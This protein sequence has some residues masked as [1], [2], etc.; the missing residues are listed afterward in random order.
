MNDCRP[1]CATLYVGLP[2]VGCSALTMCLVNKPPLG[3]KVYLT[4]ILSLFINILR[5]TSLSSLG[6]NC[7]RNLIIFSGPRTKPN[8]KPPN[9]KLFV[10]IKKRQPFGVSSITNEMLFWE[11]ITLACM[12]VMG[13]GIYRFSSKWEIEKVRSF[14]PTT[15]LNE[16]LT[17]W[18]ERSL[19]FSF[20]T[21]HL[22]F[23]LFI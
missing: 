12:G 15:L 21:N 8:T 14:S 5:E 10:C 17:S 3:Q 23:C 2:W 11:S 4:R 6:P 18:C 9:Q 1:I 19:S 20:D 7:L 22:S 13:H 16:T